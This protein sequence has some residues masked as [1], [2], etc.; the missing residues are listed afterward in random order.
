M[1]PMP[2]TRSVAPMRLRATTAAGSPKNSGGRDAMRAGASAQEGVRGPLLANGARR[3][4]AADESHIVAERQKLRGDRLD[5][6][7]MAA[8]RQVGA[9]DGALEQHVA[10]NGKALGRI[11]EHDAP[12]RVSRAMQHLERDPADGDLVAF[13]R[14]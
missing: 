3:A 14:S 13:L 12:R 10:D 6:R 8:A 4:V 7:G 1:P 2:S 11:D 5:Q 9:S